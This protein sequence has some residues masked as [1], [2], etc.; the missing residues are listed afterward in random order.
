M[1]KGQTTA[2]NIFA[3]IV[4]AMTLCANASN[5][6]ATP[7]VDP[8]VRGGAPGAGAALKGLTAD[9]T[10]FFQDGLVRF[11]QIESV[12]GGQ[13]NGLG[14]RFNSNSCLSCHVQPSVGGSSPATNPLIAIATL[15]EAKNVVPWFIAQNGPIREARFRRNPDGTNDGEVH[16]L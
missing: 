4:A 8:G 10:A 6:L 9:E 11:S 2:C 7:P 12:T 15:S 14:P 5:Q 3:G 1:T 16:D 13:N